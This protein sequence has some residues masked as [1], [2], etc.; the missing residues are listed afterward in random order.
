MTLRPPHRALAAARSLLATL[1]AF[2]VAVSLVACSTSP[3]GGSLSAVPT[4]AQAAELT[5]LTDWIN[6][7]PGTLA[8]W[9]SENRVV[10]VDFW[11]YTCVNCIRT[12]P[13][14]KQWHER[15][16]SAGLVILG[17][18][19]P[20]FEFEHDP[21]NVRRAV[22]ANG[23]TYAVA[24][25]NEMKTWN[26]FQNNAWPAKYL[27][28]AN[29]RIAYT[30]LG[31]GDYDQTEQAIRAALTEAGHDVSKIPTGG[32]TEPVQ[33]PKATTQT[34]EL[35]GGYERNFSTRGAYAAQ[36]EYYGGPDRTVEYRD[37]I[38]ERDQQV[39][40]LQGTWR[41]EAEAIVHARQTQNLEDY[42]A[43]RFTA[44]S[45]N[46]VMRPKDAATPYEVVLELDGRPLKREEAGTD[47]TFDA[48]GRSTVLVR[49]PKMYSLVILPA[50]GDREL[51]MRSNSPDFAMYA[52]T[53]GTNTSGS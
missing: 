44:R 21:G 16:A 28:D 42:V 18:H 47:V 30:H 48:S 53:F 52:V 37:I 49:E 46:V 14:L 51:K 10:L 2:G 38:G 6:A 1:T 35:Y 36:P 45:V 34:R 19:A 27:V 39:W 26:A 8:G 13:H 5:G 20:E 7:Q 12:L 22:Q 11:T 31:E 23:I 43:F 17:V 50:L 40:Y 3:G 24:L 29:G 4:N 15:Y 32:V 25:D 33:D 9:Q 41:N